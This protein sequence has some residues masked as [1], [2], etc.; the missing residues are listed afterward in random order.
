MILFLGFDG[1]RQ[2]VGSPSFNLARL[3]LLE[4]CLSHA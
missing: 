4:D 2:R 1:V 3:P